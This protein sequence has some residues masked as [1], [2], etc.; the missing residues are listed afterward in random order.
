MFVLV[1][2][3]TETELRPVWEGRDST[4]GISE[5]DYSPDGKLLAAATFDAWI[6]IYNVE[7]GYQRIG[8]SCM[9]GI[10]GWRLDLVVAARLHHG[11]GVQI[12]VAAT[13]M[14]SFARLLRCVVLAAVLL[15]C[16]SLQWP[17]CYCAHHR[18][19]RGQLHPAEQ[20]R[21]ARDT[22]L[23]PTHRYAARVTPAHC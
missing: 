7:K 2:V 17:L 22:V 8:E 1:Q 11:F 16:S 4:Q 3:V 12:R 10:S 5:L 18:L 6:D 14:N 20:L 9:M 19:E 15:V 21:C 13:D 23:E